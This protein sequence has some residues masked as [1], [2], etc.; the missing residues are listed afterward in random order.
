MSTDRARHIAKML[1]AAR[2]LDTDDDPFEIEAEDELPFVQLGH[3]VALSGA[4]PGALAL[5][6]MLA[7][8]LNTTRKDRYV[9]PTTTMLAH[10]L[11]Y[12]RYDKIKK[13]VDELVAI[14]AITVISVPDGKG[15]QKRNVYRLR[16]T[17][18]EGYSGPVSLTSFYA[19]LH[20]AYEEETA[21]QPV[22]PQ[23]GV[24]VG[25]QTGAH[26]GP[27]TGVVTTRSLNNKK[28]AAPSGGVAPA[29]R[30]R[31]STGS[32][33]AEAGSG[34]AASGK[35][36]SPGNGT[37]GSGS[38]GAARGQG[39]TAAAGKNKITPEERKVRDALLPLLPPDFRQAL[40][41]IIPTNVVQDIVKALAAGQPRERTVQQL[42]QYRV[43]PRWERYW[44]VKFYA[45]ELTPELSAGKKRKP[46]GPLS[47]MLADTAEC[48]NLS[49]EDRHDFVTADACQMCEMRK[50]DK[51]ADR[52]R[53]RQAPAEEPNIGSPKAPGAT[54]PGVPAQGSTGRYCE[55]PCNRKF[56]PKADPSISICRECQAEMAAALLNS[57]PTMP[58]M[59][60]PADAAAYEEF[61]AELTADEPVVSAVEEQRSNKEDDDAA[62]TDRI[63]AE[64]AAQFGTSEQRAAYANSAG[65]PP[66]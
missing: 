8:H 4:S 26:V 60:T 13:F 30:R 27:R 62:E 47:Q 53:E 63:R 57:D 42:V 18:P 21:G 23:M 32:R 29:E 25:P 28:N 65:T 16:R 66:F 54:T 2:K 41:N 3:W 12:S 58:D 14:G 15:P 49:C 17:P 7:M 34:V 61:A 36:S 24:D 9:W 10:M 52:D 43:M 5:Y 35:D 64:I 45:G 38:T 6:W 59:W 22:H 46:F 1:G 40:G 37:A 55:G 33:E 48:G 20:E 19:R 31:L 50:V 11:G 51:R 39:T 44:S 56:G